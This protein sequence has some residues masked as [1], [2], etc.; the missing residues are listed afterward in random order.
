M[1]LCCLFASSSKVSALGETFAVSLGPRQRSWDTE[2]RLGC[3]RGLPRRYRRRSKA[4]ACASSAVARRS[5]APPLKPG[6]QPEP[7]RLQPASPQHATTLPVL[8]PL[9]LSRELQAYAMQKTPLA[10]RPLFSGATCIWDKIAVHARP[11]LVWPLPRSVPS[12]PLP[13][14]HD[15]E[16]TEKRS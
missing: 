8:R 9:F 1:S 14:K 13:S 3:G 15:S 10:N 6:T 4:S 2:A 5:G 16:R 12:T 11:E 7:R